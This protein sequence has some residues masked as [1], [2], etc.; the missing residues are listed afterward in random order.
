MNPSKEFLGPAGLF[1][2]M[3]ACLAVLCV[4]FPTSCGPDEQPAPHAPDDA[5]TATPDFRIV[6]LSPAL[7]D[8][9]VELGLAPF[10]V[11]RDRFE[12]RLPDDVPRVG[13]LE[14]IDV[15][16]L[17]R[18][19][20]SDLVLQRGERG[21]EP[22]LRNLVA[23]RG[24][25]VVNVR[26]DDVDD[27]AA[28]ADTLVTE[29]TFGGDDALRAASADAAAALVERL[30]AG[31]APLPPAVAEQ[32]GSAL[33]L[34]SIDPIWALGPGSHLGDVLE[35]LGLAH[36]V[37]PG[38]PYRRL[39]AEDLVGLQAG[40]VIHVVGAARAGDGSTTPVRVASGPDDPLVRTALGPLARL[41]MPAVDAG[42]VMM[43]VHPRA[44][45]PGPSVLEV[46]A[47]L[48][49]ALIEAAAVGSEEG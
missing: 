39:A 15:E 6:V 14:R 24:W 29:L 9:L 23:E 28:A 47:L 1:A 37:G 35:D 36:A 27:I 42:R 49:S 45:L 46:G 22:G 34:F 19:K 13:D 40:V 7:A 38:T 41:G 32:L 20:P 48:R 10:I 5:S 25:N 26:I 11:G 43:L 2:R 3:V 33:L 44:L 16:A 12:T 17:L 8:L 4:A 18:L 31:I 30:E 21:L